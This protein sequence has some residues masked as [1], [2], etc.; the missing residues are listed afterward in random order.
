MG[1]W[2]IV[3]RQLDKICQY[4]EKSGALGNGFVLERALNRKR[5]I[6]EGVIMC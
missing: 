3:Y 6:A 4:E 1:L 2:V 5:K